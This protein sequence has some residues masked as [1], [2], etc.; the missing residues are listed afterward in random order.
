MELYSRQQDLCQIK[1]T[2][3]LPPLWTNNEV[4]SGPFLGHFLEKKL[5]YSILTTVLT[6]NITLR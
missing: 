5:V 2:W 1:Y 3:L 4:S 6:K